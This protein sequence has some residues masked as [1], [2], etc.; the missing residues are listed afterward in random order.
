MIYFKR[1]NCM[2]C[3]L[4]VHK[5]SMLN[6]RI[7]RH[8]TGYVLWTKGVG[9]YFLG[10]MGLAAW[11]PVEN[12]A[13]G[14]ARTRRGSRNCNRCNKARRVSQGADSPPPFLSLQEAKVLSIDCQLLFST[15]SLPKKAIKSVHIQRKNGC[16]DT[17]LYSQNSSNR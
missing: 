13:E 3:E 16:K 10:E 5:A 1:V 9:S 2:V 6:K 8:G 17:F 4:Y 7:K 11:A 14:K 12:G 15:D